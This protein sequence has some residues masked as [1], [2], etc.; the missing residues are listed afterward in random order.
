MGNGDDEDCPFCSIVEGR[1]DAHVVHEDDE[2]LA[3]LDV[4]PVSRG[5]TLV[6][7]KQHAGEITDLDSDTTAAVFDL[8]RQ[9][10]D[11]QRRGLNPEGVNI[12]QSNGEAA[13]QE[14]HHMHVHVIPRYRNDGLFFSFDAGD[15]D[16]EEADEVIEAVQ[17]RL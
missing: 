8:A 15:L 2:A 17:A 13:G 4:N 3:F 10:A 7:P 6:V 5:H 11:A 12:L 9:V 16:D 14:I 1:M